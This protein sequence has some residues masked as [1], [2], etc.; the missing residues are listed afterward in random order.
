MVDLEK[1]DEL[2]VLTESKPLV[3]DVKEAP[4]GSLVSMLET[5]RADYDAAQQSV[6][7]DLERAFGCAA[8]VVPLVRHALSVI[9]RE[10][11][12]TTATLLRREVDLF[13]ELKRFEAKVSGILASLSMNEIV[14]LSEASLHAYL[15]HLFL[16]SEDTTRLR[17]W[18]IVALFFI[19][20]VLDV[21]PRQSTLAMPELVTAE[22]LVSLL[23]DW[24]AFLH[25]TPQ[26]TEPLRSQKHSTPSNSLSAKQDDDA[27]LRE[28]TKGW[29]VPVV[30]PPSEGKLTDLRAFGFASQ[31]LVEQLNHARHITDVEAEMHSKLPPFFDTIPDNFE[32]L[33][34]EIDETKG[35]AETMAQ[36]PLTGSALIAPPGIAITK[37]IDSEIMVDWFNPQYIA[38]AEEVWRDC[39]PGEKFDFIEDKHLSFVWLRHV[40]FLKPILPE[41]SP[42][43]LWLFSVSVKFHC[44]KYI[45]EMIQNEITQGNC[46][47]EAIFVKFV[48]LLRDKFTE[49]IYSKAMRA[50]YISARPDDPEDIENFALRKEELYYGQFFDRDDETAVSRQKL[51]AHFSLMIQKD[52]SIIALRLKHEKF[53]SLV[54]MAKAIKNESRKNKTIDDK[55]TVLKRPPQSIIDTLLKSP[56]NAQLRLNPSAAVIS[57]LPTRNHLIDSDS[58]EDSDFE[59]EH[60]KW[61]DT[62]TGKCMR[63]GELG[64]SMKLCRSPLPK[65]NNR[66]D[67][68]GNFGHDSTHCKPR[69]KLDCLRCGGPHSTAVCR[70]SLYKIEKNKLLNPGIL[71]R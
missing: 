34:P 35:E 28:A 1:L 52:L 49:T 30:D 64:H 55:V 29:E 69:V 51:Q 50:A 62:T 39:G 15:K 19:E 47:V 61:Y 53:P 44:D 21:W 66:C 43:C 59:E 5:S 37:S 54:E 25:K 4:K 16:Q 40:R 70:E 57:K 63:C 38:Q 36:T 8:E 48:D 22:A 7:H 65:Q 60:R 24:D 33:E 9:Y 12:S 6:G 56:G 20:Y 3:V 23:A 27:L 26:M 32:S 10:S 42:S 68:C 58:S 2:I 18:R 67:K 46:S 31:P 17:R 45:T 13:L 11:K 41:N 71:R 14:L